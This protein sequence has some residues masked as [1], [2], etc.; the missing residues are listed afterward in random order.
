MTEHV[1]LVDSENRVL[2]TAPKATVHTGNTPLHRAFSL[3]IFNS[4]GELLLQQRSQIKKTW[5]LVWSNSC[6]GHPALDETNEAAVRRR[7]QQELG[8]ELREIFEVLPEYRYRAEQDGIQENEICPVFIS[9]T[10]EPPKINPDEIE[11]IRWIPWA[12][13]VS[14]IKENP[15]TYSPW[16]EEETLLLYHNR[17]LH[18][19]FQ[20][21]LS[22]Y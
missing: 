8:L 16:C 4:R 9:F 22:R 2:G 1:V 14:E 18:D 10:D 6:C 12:N 7:A 15:G 21:H 3:F 13:F 20:V 17:T 19:L 11:E 5:P